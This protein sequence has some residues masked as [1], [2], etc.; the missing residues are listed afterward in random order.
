MSCPCLCHEREHTAHS[1]RHTA[2]STR[3]TAHGTRHTYTHHTHSMPGTHTA[4]LCFLNF[5]VIATYHQDYVA[6]Q[7][8]CDN[9]SPLHGLER[10]K[11]T[12]H[13]GASLLQL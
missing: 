7:P 4:F 6:P 1:T 12:Q 8:R 3:H 10:T 5:T 11:L 9:V 2:H 13:A